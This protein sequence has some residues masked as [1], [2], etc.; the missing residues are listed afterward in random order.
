ML[1]VSVI[2]VLK[3][4]IASLL[5]LSLIICVSSYEQSSH[6][7][8]IV[9]LLKTLSH[10]RYW[11]NEQRIV[12]KEISLLM[13]AEFW[14]FVKITI[15]INKEF[16]LLKSGVRAICYKKIELSILTSYVEWSCQSRC[17]KDPHILSLLY[18]RVHEMVLKLL[19]ENKT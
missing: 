2:K 14:C 9:V 7:K 1:T 12:Y 6:K 17:S 4:A 10:R 15:I 18:Q 11:Q 19:E 3:I 8:G 16:C 5:L 13:K